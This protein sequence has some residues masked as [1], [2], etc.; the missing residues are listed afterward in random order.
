METVTGRET[1]VDHYDSHSNPSAA[2][3]RKTRRNLVGIVSILL[4]VQ[5]MGFGGI[6]FFMPESLQEILHEPLLTTPLFAVFADAVLM[7]LALLTL[8]ASVGF[9]FVLRAGWLLA[10]LVQGFTQLG[11]LVFY[12]QLKPGFVYPVM[13]YCIMMVLYL[14]SYSIRVTFQATGK[15]SPGSEVI[16]E[17]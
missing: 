8:L 7:P 12:F 9:Y 1:E 3:P 5:A 10:M 13:T 16:D 15:I 17:I 11:C 4:V 2:E 14:N 6:R